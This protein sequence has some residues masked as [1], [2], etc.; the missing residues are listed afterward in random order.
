LSWPD[1]DGSTGGA[2]AEVV[3][4]AAAADFRLFTGD[5]G[6]DDGFDFLEI[7]LGGLELTKPSVSGFSSLLALVLGCC[8]VFNPEKRK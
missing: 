4:A 3:A 7:L 2:E 5:G 1:A 6:A 8:L